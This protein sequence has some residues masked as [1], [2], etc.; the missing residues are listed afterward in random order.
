M[1][2]QINLLNTAF[3]KTFDW[4]SAMPLAIAS[5]GLL[6]LILVATAFAWVQSDARQKTADQLASRLKTAQDKLTAM[7]KSV[8]DSKPDP[9]LAADLASTR[10]LLKSRE[11]IM[12]ILEGGG[13]GYTSGFAE[14]LRGLA[15]QVPNGLWLTGFTIGAGGNEMEIRGRML[16][17]DLLPQYIQRLN[18]EKVFKGQSFAALTIQRPDEAKDK[19]S[20]AAPP[21]STAGPAGPA[22]AR[23]Q[24]ALPSFVEFVLKP[25][26]QSPAKPAVAITPAAPPALGDALQLPGILKPGTTP[27]VPASGTPAPAEKKS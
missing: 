19:R 12:K 27:A 17:P 18:T 7:V 21:A 22:A 8:A 5:G 15:R 3:R 9:K 20:A 4:L 11:E 23:A 26:T 25:S 24:A 1:S 14:Y 10:A 2:Q 16:S 6:A 13:I